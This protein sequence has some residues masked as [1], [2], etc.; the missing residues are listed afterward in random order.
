HQDLPFEKLVEAVQPERHL[1]RSPLF[2]TKLVLQ[3]V[4]TGAFELSDLSLST[5]EIENNTSRIDL[6]LAIK[7]GGEYLSGSL[8]YSTELFDE[9]TVKRMLAHYTTLLESIA[10]NPEQK[11]SNL[12]FVS[13]A[14]LGQLLDQATGEKADY[15]KHNC[16]HEL[17]EAQVEK[18]PD[19]IA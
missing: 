12:S 5:I 17:F 8:E 1:S 4:P 2:Q 11:I 14:E 6:T 13:E 19:A 10:A 16:I 18:T 7:D 9:S 15:P 3:N